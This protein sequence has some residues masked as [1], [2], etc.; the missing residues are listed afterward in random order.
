VIGKNMSLDKHVELSIRTKSFAL[1]IIKLAEALPRTRS[2]NVISHQ[3]LRSA[4]SMAANYRACGRARSK[5][6]FIAKIGIVIEEADEIVLRLEL[7][8]ESAIIPAARLENLL[9]EANQLLSI[10]QLP[11]GQQKMAAKNS[12]RVVGFR[13]RAITRSPDHPIP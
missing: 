11:E 2:A 8:V 6:E 7:L 4:T 9:A 13:S 12:E 10:F 5:A 3:I 1:R